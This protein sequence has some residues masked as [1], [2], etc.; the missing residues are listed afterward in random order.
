MDENERIISFNA[1]KNKIGIQDLIT[2]VISVFFN[3]KYTHT[4]GGSN[5]KKN[6]KTIKRN[7]KT[8]KKNRKTIKR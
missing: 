7:R 6:R 5:I 8:I 2:P 1:I 3:S 4:V